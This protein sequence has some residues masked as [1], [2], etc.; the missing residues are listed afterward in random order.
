MLGERAKPVSV[1]DE[2]GDRQRWVG[3][4][5]VDDYDGW[6]EL[7]F[8]AYLESAIGTAIS[9]RIFTRI[10]NDAVCG[11]RIANRLNSKPNGLE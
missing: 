6:E 11:R 7:G 2:L 10:P 8:T 5:L 4:S 1:K 9:N 3:M